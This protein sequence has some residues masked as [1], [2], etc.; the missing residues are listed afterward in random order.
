MDQ[1]R[2]TTTELTA[3][4]W[5]GQCGTAMI[6][7]SLPLFLLNQ[8]I[9]GAVVILFGSYFVYRADRQYNKILD[10]LKIK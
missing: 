3:M 7:L 10:K 6:V 4:V 8:P 2:I 9:F 5:I 1:H